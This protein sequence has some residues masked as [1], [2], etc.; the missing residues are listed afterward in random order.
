MRHQCSQPRSPWPWLARI[1]QRE[2]LRLADR[3]RDLLLAE[4]AEPAGTDEP[5]RAEQL[6]VRSAVAELSA[7]DQRLIWLRYADDQTYERIA[8]ALGLPE[9]T[10]KVRLH[11]A[12]RRLRDV[13]S[14]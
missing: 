12:R 6:T 7:L 8:D 3:R 13:L 5:D 1:C 11:R 10:V 14:S 2:A 4:P 9:G